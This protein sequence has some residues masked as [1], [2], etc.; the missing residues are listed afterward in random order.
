MAFSSL[1]SADFTVSLGC[2]ILALVSLSAQEPELENIV[3]P[4]PALATPSAA[5][6]PS[7]FSSAASPRPSA[8]PTPVQLT[9]ILF[10]GL[11][12]RSIGPAVM[13]GRVS[14]VA[15]DPHNPAIFYVGLG[16]GGV[17]KTSNN[18]VTFDPIFDKQPVLS[19]GAIAIA[20]SDA[21]VIWVGTG[22]AND[23]N[24][25]EW[26]DGVYH[27][28]D[29]GATW[30]HVGLTNS[31]TIARIVVHPK[32]PEVAYVA[33]MGNLW[34]DGG[35]RGLY[36]TTDGGKTWKLIL[37]APSPNDVRTG[38][39]DVALD[40][41]NSET[42]YAA[43]YARQR[44]PW[45]FAY[46]VTATNGADVGG[47]FKSID[48]GATW[49][50]CG[51]GLPGATGRIGLAVSASKAKTVMAIVESDEGGASDLRDIHSRRGGV[52]RSE[53]G[54]ENWTRMS[55][56]NPRPFYFSQIRIDPANDQRVYVLGMAVLVSDDGGKSFRED[57]SEKLHPDCHAL[58]LQPG[59]APAPK[60]AK[61]GEKNKTP[62][63]QRLIL[64][65]DGGVYQ[66]Y[67]AGKSWE[68][69]DRFPAGEY[70]RITLDDMQPFYRIAGGLQD[71]ESF[72]GPGRTASKDGIRNSDWTALE[73]GDG[74]Y[75]VF[76]PKDRDVLYAESQ[77]GFIHRINL[78][79]GERRELRPEAAEGQER[80]RFHWNTPLIGSRHQPGVLFLAGNRVFRLTNN[81]EHF[82]VIS[83]DLTRNEPGKID[84]AGSGAENYGVIYSLAESPVKDGML[85]AGTDD[86]RLW[87][88]QDEGK[89][90]V[91]L[92]SRLPEPVRDQWIVRIEPGTKDAKVAYVATNAYRS[93]DDRPFI[94]RTA[95][96]GQTWQNMAGEGL[97]PNDPLEV[98]RQDPVNPDL[99]Y[100]GTHFGLFASFNGGGRWVQVGDLPNVRVDDLQ[101]QPRTNDLVIA[102][103]GRSLA[104]LDDTRPFREL[105]PQVLAE[106]AHLFPIATA[107]GF[108]LL[109]G[110]ADWNGKG[111]Y[112]GENPPE[113]ALITFWVK[114]FT[115]DE[116]KIAITNSSGQPVANLK[117]PGSPGMNRVCW[118][119]RPTEDVRIKYGGDDPKKF[120]PS[121]DYIAELSYGRE[122]MKQTFHVEIAEGITTR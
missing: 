83:P 16:T 32:K 68:H 110:G 60:P 45:S 120:V 107:R 72:V 94:L 22:E 98:V 88:T 27:S 31:R 39:G 116:V 91:E 114:S 42:V 1:R 99:L 21:D 26:G 55:D 113:G 7:L 112:R 4:P 37:H 10:K 51:G 3:S 57:L 66:S 34:K 25:S 44:T 35:E 106:P 87:V 82:Q 90:W 122:K 89:N 121:G 9:D 15:I 33:A 19:I 85:W 18:G 108:Y 50:K 28:S 13:G 93:G 86:G 109:S 54:G 62:V 67:A 74:F 24:S 30:D 38:C 17:F 69:L 77:E 56:I 76:D 105:T 96:L 104:I 73:G 64:G 5:P 80:Y 117:A 40:P 92:T 46:G 58:A 8:S 2:S 95:D 36:K 43:L 12:A 81:A 119:L 11:K 115:G 59:S 52:F 101:I 63:S 47:I 70:Y 29:A 53:D 71:N 6:S 78:R 118:D 65:T 41:S 20:P 75:V 79:N 111:V 97:P 61:P 100:V 84:A 14:D 49:K 102:T 23:R 103:H 48:G